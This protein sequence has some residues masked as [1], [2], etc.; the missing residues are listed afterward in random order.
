[1]KYNYVNHY[2]E[3]KTRLSFKGNKVNNK[4]EEDMT[5][6]HYNGSVYMTANFKDDKLFGN[7]IRFEEDGKMIMNENYLNGK[8]EGKSEYYD[9][10]GNLFYTCMYKNG[11]KVRNSTINY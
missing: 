9:T 10:E 3:N 4:R 2:D 6:Y 11:R 5:W 7:V 8:L 1:M